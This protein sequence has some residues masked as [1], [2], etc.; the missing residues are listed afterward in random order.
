MCVCN[1][2]SYVNSLEV[3]STQRR[4][5][6]FSLSHLRDEM[7]VLLGL[8]RAPL[9]Q[10]GLSGPSVSEMTPPS[11]GQCRASVYRHQSHGDQCGETPEGLLSPA[12]VGVLERI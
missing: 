12:G 1:R 6:R 5:W 4:K 11:T 10:D 7:E 9:G 2:F 3:L 8:T